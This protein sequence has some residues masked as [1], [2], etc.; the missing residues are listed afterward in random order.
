MPR[1]VGPPRRDRRAPP[2]RRCGGRGARRAD[3]RDRR[4]PRWRPRTPIDRPPRPRATR[5][6]PA[7]PGRRRPMTRLGHGPGARLVVGHAVIERAVGLHVADPRPARAGHGVE[8][9][10]LRQDLLGDLGRGHVHGPAAE[11]L[12]VGVRGMGARPPRPAG[13]RPPRCDAWCRGPRRGRRRPR[14]HSSP[15][16]GGPR[17]LVVPRRRRRSGR[18]TASASRRSTP[19]AR[20]SGGRPRRAR[21][22]AWRRPARAASVNSSAVVAR[23]GGHAHARRQ[24]HE[25][26]VGALEV[27][28]APGAAAR[29]RRPRPG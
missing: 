13:R 8:R 28:H 12:A 20:L 1:P 19:A 18:P 17:R 2:R 24:G 27:E 9:G 21:G 29:D 14:W 15:G 22:R 25:V 26:E 3:R 16:R 10:Q 11:P 6:G 4:R 5:P 23:R 7:G